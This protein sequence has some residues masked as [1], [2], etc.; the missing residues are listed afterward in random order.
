ME[1]PTPSPPPQ[2]AGL[3]PIWLVAEDYPDD[4]SAALGEVAA[5]CVHRNFKT[6]EAMED[7]QDVERIPVR[8]VYDEQIAARTVTVRPSHMNHCQLPENEAFCIYVTYKRR[9]DAF[10]AL[11]RM[12]GVLFELRVR[13]DLASVMLWEETA[14]FETLGVMLDNSRCAVMNMDTVF[15]MLRTCALLGMN[16]FQLYTEDT[17]QIEDEPFFG[18]LRGGFTQD[19]MS[20][21]DNY[22]SN[23]GIEVFPCIQTLGHLGQVLQWPRFASVRDT[24]EVILAG[25]EETYQLI[26]KM[27]RAAT[28]PLQSKRIHIGMDEAHGVGEGRYKQIFGDK[29]SSE[30]FLAHLTRVQQMCKDLGLK[31]MVWSDMLFTLAA[32]NSSLQSYYET[33]DLPQEMKHNMPED[34]ELV[35]WDYYHTQPD[36]YSRKIEQHRDLGFEP[37]VAG[38][39][40]SWNRLFSALPFSFAASDACLKACKRDRVKNVFVTTWGDDGNECDIMSA[41]PGFV[42]YSEHC[43]TAND[44]VDFSAI[45]RTFAGVCGGNLDDFMYTAKLDVPLE[46]MDKSRFPPNVSKWLLWNDPFY[47]FF[48]PQYEGIDLAAQYREI[49]KRLSN[50]CTG[51]CLQL[52]PLNERLEFGVKM[53]HVLSL[54]AELRQKL[55]EAWKSSDQK[56]QLYNFARGP[57]QELRQATD[58]LWKYHRDK[59]WLATYRPFGMEIIEMRYGALRTRLETL[60]DRIIAFCED[61][62]EQRVNT[63]YPS[64]RP[65]LPE[66]DVELREVYTGVGL[67][68][69][70]DFARA[71]T[72]N[73]ALGTG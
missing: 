70:L 32:K 48:T 27:L 67:E 19:D 35:Y 61:D 1:G 2:R 38:G 14:Q 71:Y 58:A 16:T 26:E 42:H 9:N 21:I 5:Y 44:D 23:F 20:M 46:S 15:Y 7:S 37:W 22:A 45:K 63:A 29:D 6:R 68:A 56:S 49:G 36:A 17:Y 11:G 39:I 13:S 73:R 52:Y 28:K 69:V 4:I 51:D 62:G 43:Y 10:R 59:V 54:K 31:P 8:F 30:V 25:S 60:Q 18:Y 57:L 64:A 55:V 41:L 50:V 40:W 3:L 34:L 66:L 65:D 33:A 12:L 53:A 72:P 24:H 47:G